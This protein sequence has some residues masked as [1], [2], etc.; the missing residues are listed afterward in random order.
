M[1]VVSRLFGKK[2]KVRNDRVNVQHFHKIQ[3]LID[4]NEYVV[5]NVSVTGLGFIDKDSNK[6]FKKN[7]IIHAVV[8]VL[9]QFCDIQ[10]SIRHNNNALVGCRVLT[11]C[12]IYRKY[13]EDYFGSELEGLKLRMISAE[14]IKENEYG[15]PS[16][17]YGDYNHE[18]YFT[19]KEEQIT[20]FQI[21]FHGQI[22]SF[23][24]G[25]VSTGVVWEDEREDVTHKSSDLIKE[26]SKLSKEMMEFIFRFVEV[27]QDIKKPY[28]DQILSLIDKRFKQDWKK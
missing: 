4:E 10:I 20:S 28:K 7:K 25:K 24:D 1:G 21:N 3:L 13:V 16:W 9:D 17:L 8:K 23:A 11:S 19:V 15:D 18:I 27:A 26:S 14:N 12:E 6:D 5:E 2:V 22:V